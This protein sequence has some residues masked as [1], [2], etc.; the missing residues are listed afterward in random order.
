MDCEQYSFSM[1]SYCV[2]K[3]FPLQLYQTDATVR[4]QIIT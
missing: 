3:R 2:E 1:H 4:T